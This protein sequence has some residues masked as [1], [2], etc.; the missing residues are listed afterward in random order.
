MSTFLESDS[1]RAEIIAY[2]AKGQLPLKYAYAGSAAH[3]HDALAQLETY[4]SVVGSDEVR[5]VAS[6]L[7]G[8]AGDQIVEI[9]PG[10]GRHSAALLATAGHYGRYLGLDFS[11]TL[12]GIAAQ[13]LRSG[14]VRADTALWDVEQGPTTAIADWRRGPSPVVVLFLG[15]T[16]GNVE[17]VPATLRNI[18]ESLRPGDRLLLGLSARVP[19]ATAEDY[20]APYRNETFRRAALEPLL[21]V[22]VPADAIDDRLGYENDEVVVDA[23]LRT[24]VT[25][26]DAELAAGERVRCF[27]SRRF[28]AAEVVGLLADGGW[29]TDRLQLDD[30]AGR[31][32][33]GAVAADPDE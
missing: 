31:L 28:Q 14:G 3:T 21:A 11:R 7:R 15:Q 9:G 20:L 10:N 8:H 27:R 24:A 33:V 1:H 26:D 13:S 32:I 30:T 5:E 4:A 19:G 16:L 2:I 6:F 25:L 23:V 18:R 22:G 12:L 17:D 29:S